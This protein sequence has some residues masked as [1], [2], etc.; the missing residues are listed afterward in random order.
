MLENVYHELSGSSMFMGSREVEEE[1]LR[2]MSRAPRTAVTVVE[3]K[4][5]GKQQTWERTELIQVA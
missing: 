2:A 4:V 1:W 5:A 3:D